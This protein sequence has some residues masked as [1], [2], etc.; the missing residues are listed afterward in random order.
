[1]RKQ[2]HHG[3]FPAVCFETRGSGF[4]RPECHLVILKSQDFSMVL[5]NRVV[6]NS[7]VVNFCFQSGSG[8]DH[9]PESQYYYIQLRK[10]E[11]IF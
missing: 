1:M 11:K 5:G 3:K 10:N 7:F 4:P 2:I 8:F 6:Q 9:V